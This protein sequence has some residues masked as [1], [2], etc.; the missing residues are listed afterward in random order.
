MEAP[1]PLPERGKEAPEPETFICKDAVSAISD[2]DKVPML[3]Y[4]V[5]CKVM[6][7]NSEVDHLCFN[8]HKEAAGFELDT[9][10][11]MYVKKAK[12]K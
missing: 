8:C 6:P 11:N 3:G 1:K 7:S 12:R 5:K 4:C 9:D 2:A 10:K